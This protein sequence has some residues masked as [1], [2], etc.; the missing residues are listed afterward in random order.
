MINDF[1]NK[2][3]YPEQSPDI[4]YPSNDSHLFIDY[5]DSDEFDFY[6][7]EE[8]LH[9]TRTRTPTPEHIKILDM[10]CGTGILGLCMLFKLIHLL[11]L[12][13]KI[14]YK[15][16][17]LDLVD[18]NPEAI[19][20]TKQFIELNR[21]LI[22][23]NESDLGF[24]PKIEINYY[25]SDLFTGINRDNFRQPYDFIIFNPPYL[26]SE[27]Q[28]IP[29]SR[30]KNIDL[31]WDGGDESGNATILRFFE[32]IPDKICNH[33]QIYTISSNHADIRHYLEAIETK[34]DIV[35]LQSIHIFFEDILLFL[36]KL[37]QIQHKTN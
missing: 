34:F 3:K 29:E 37:K 23:P 31:A 14:K 30:K 12:E 5:I 28:M 24:K 6:R 21:N 15:Q 11:N 7:V 1:I 32:Q 13:R 18:I 9:E 10:G 8:F 16:Y 4:Y 20:Y 19:N 17:T 22:L 25:V 33:T 26:P 36:S 2:L 27:P 35:L